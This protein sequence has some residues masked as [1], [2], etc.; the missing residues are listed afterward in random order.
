MA[1]HPR[2]VPPYTIGSHRIL[3][4]SV[5]CPLGHVNQLGINQVPQP[6]MQESRPAILSG[7]RPTY[8]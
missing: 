2:L 1:K 7:E 4:N 3:K 6:I 5:G 8:E